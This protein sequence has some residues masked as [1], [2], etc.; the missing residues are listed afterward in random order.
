MGLSE[1]GW[2]NKSNSISIIMVFLLKSQ[3]LMIHSHFPLVKFVFFIVNPRIHSKSPL[4]TPVNSHVDWISQ[5]LSPK[6][7]GLRICSAHHGDSSRQKTTHST[8]A[9]AANLLRITTSGD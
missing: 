3:V 7:S 9:L 4:F 1:N 5:P 2:L 8:A 6:K